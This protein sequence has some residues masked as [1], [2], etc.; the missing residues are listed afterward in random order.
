[1]C[2]REQQEQGEQSG[3]E[4]GHGKEP[5]LGRGWAAEKE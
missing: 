1:M 3:I 5:V 4:V 2:R